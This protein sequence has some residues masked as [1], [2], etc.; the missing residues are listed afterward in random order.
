M[1]A[2]RMVAPR[3]MEFITLPDP[4]AGPGQV[5]VRMKEVAVCGS[6]LVAYLATQP[7]TFPLQPGHPAHECVGEVVESGFDG[8]KPGDRVLFF[9][10]HQDG[11]CELAVAK[12]PT[13]LLKLPADGS[14]SEWMMA[15][16]LGTIIHAA[17]ELGTVM[18]DR[19][20]VI[21]QGPVGQ[22]FNHLMWNLGADMVIGIDRIPER[23]AIS[24]KM[25]ATHTV[26]VATQDVRAEVRKLTDGRGV[27]TIIEASGYD[28]TLEM[29]IDLVRRDG[30]VLMFG[31]PKHLA[32]TF[33]IM[34]MYNKRLKVVT[35]TGPEVDRDIGMALRYIQ[36]G[37]ITV[38]PI[39][40]HR[41][42]FDRVRDAYELFAERKDGCVKVVVEFP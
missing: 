18:S 11:L 39:L 37:R 2:V 8:F 36:H 23:L 33:P 22:L 13:Q 21:G 41:F 24:P 6:D 4:T 16:V 40:T 27:D 9:P 29:M 25:H 10:E 5:L 35:T 31:Q 26:N 12:L 7:R 15:Q 1:R 38:K 30:R 32:V 19:I 17:R 28:E 3:T 34:Q 14:L 20:A 42:P